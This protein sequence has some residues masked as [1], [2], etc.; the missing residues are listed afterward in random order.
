MGQRRGPPG[1]GR[2]KGSAPVSFPP[3]ERHKRSLGE[4][5]TRT[6]Y[7]VKV[8]QALRSDPKAIADILMRKVKDEKGAG[9]KAYSKQ[10]FLGTFSGVM[11]EEDDKESG[12]MGR[13]TF[14]TY[15][16]RSLATVTKE[17]ESRIKALAEGETPRQQ[18]PASSYGYFANGVSEV[19]IVVMEAEDEE[20]DDE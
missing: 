5:K 10:H 14:G 11:Y 18:G 12:K 4:G 7:T 13:G 8:P 3:I 6:V 17:L 2:S 19:S 16:S 20:E 9:G 15:A 1:R